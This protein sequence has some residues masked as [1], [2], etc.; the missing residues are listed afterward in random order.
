MQRILSGSLSLALVAGLTNGLAAQTQR[1]PV[2]RNTTRQAAPAARTAQAPA[3]RPGPN[4]N[5]PAGAPRAPFQLSPQEEA[6]LDQL[7]QAWEA[8]GKKI[9]QFSVSFTRLEYRQNAIAAAPQAPGNQAAVAVKT[10]GEI[11]YK[12]P[13]KGLYVTRDDKDVEVDHWVTDGKTIFLFNPDKKRVE[14]HELPPQLQ[15]KGIEDGPLPF[16]FGTEAA[17]LKARY[18]LRIDPPGVKPQPGQLLLEATPKFQADAQNYR[19]AQVILDAESLTMLGL[20][21]YHP[22]GKSRTVHVFGTPVINPKFQFLQKD[23][24]KPVTPPGWQLVPVP[25]QQPAAEPPRAAARPNAGK[26]APRG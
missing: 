3:Q 23:F 15:G 5:V 10:T 19:R 21:I 2:Q 11:K 22:D 26:T 16:L 7:L 4:I 14:A 20:Q 1:V 17:K 8:A 6:Q 9:D 24:S 13:D 25:L 18:W 12:R